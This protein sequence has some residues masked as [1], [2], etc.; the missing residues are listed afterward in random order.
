MDICNPFLPQLWNDEI[1]HKK[2]FPANR[3]LANVIPV[4]EIKD[5]V[6]A[7]NEGP[8]SVLA[9][10]SKVFGKVMQK[11]FNNFIYKFLSPFLCCC[12]KGYST[13]F[14]L[15]SLTLSSQRSLSYRNQS[16]DLQSQ[17]EDWFL[18]VRDLR[19]ERAN[20]KM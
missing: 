11:Q 8:V 17:S 13:Q 12:R 5:S 14:S 6:L 4:N 3:R 10:V 2:V 20:G 7:E 1:I 16:I 19:H 15:M 18:Y 9:T